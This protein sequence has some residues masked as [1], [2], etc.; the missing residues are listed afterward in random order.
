MKIDL[1]SLSF[2]F[3]SLSIITSVF[4]AVMFVLILRIIERKNQLVETQKQQVILLLM[5]EEMK[6]TS[7]NLT[8][9]CRS[10]V[11]T[12]DDKY[13]REYE[14]IVAWKNG[15][16]PRPSSVHHL[17]SPGIMISQHALLKKLG[18]SKT[19]LDLLVKSSDFSNALVS[20]ENQ[21][22]DSVARGKYVRGPFTMQE[23]ENLRSF[24]LRIL[25]DENYR[26]HISL[27]NAPIEEFFLKLDMR[28]SKRVDKAIA[29]LNLSAIVTLVMMVILMFWIIGS[30][31]NIRKNIVKPVGRLSKEFEVFGNGDLRIHITS[32]RT[33]EI[34]KM[35]NSFNQTAENMKKLVLSINGIVNFL[36]SVGDD[37]ST[38]TTETASA[39]NEISGNIEGVKQQATIQQNTANHT[40][41][42]LEEI[43]STIKTLSK[44]IEKQEKSILGSSS[45]VKEIVENISK[46]TDTLQS[47]DEMI[48]QLSHSTNEGKDTL[49]RS[50]AITQK[51]T[52][53]SGSLMEASS[54]IQHIASQ[55]NLLAMNA[56]IE[57]AHAGEAGKGFAVVADEIR[58]LAE[59][60]STQ[61]KTIT[62]TLKNLSGELTTLSEASILAKD[63]FSSIFSLSQKLKEI[64]QILAETMGK[65]EKRNSLVLEEIKAM[66]VI[67]NE[68]SS[69]STEMLKQSE[70]IANEMK[71]LTDLTTLIVASM[72]EMATGAIQINQAVQGISEISQ[73][74]K[75]A[76]DD[77]VNEMS[78]F[79]L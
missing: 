48:N 28:M 27:I 64:S 16:V 54:V 3:A 71:T 20:V 23:N 43:I 42:T 67:T 40:F 47:V 12:G 75:K 41:I 7:T 25:Y 46:I 29:R 11:A 4:L 39:M 10:F 79:T 58:K 69:D 21:A 26:K 22:M 73:R 55:T 32:K 13:R 62:D 60:S 5:A 63:K 74:N 68:V 49:S 36:S 52:E 66:N 30:L 38:N 78:K 34:G 9:L 33:D 56:A 31:L 44:N 14:E 37:L 24:A 17:L 8:N 19:E 2:K 59:E 1:K 35:V 15:N 45:S 61:G 65:Q 6:E 72:N 53:E 76:I 50:N 57:A 51:I 77:L 18:C 70:N